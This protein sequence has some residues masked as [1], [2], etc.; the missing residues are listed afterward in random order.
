MQRLKF[1]N[2]ISAVV[3]GVFIGGS[4]FLNLSYDTNKA[5]VVAD[6][7]VGIPVAE[8]SWDSD[9]QNNA[10]VRFSLS[11]GQTINMNKKNNGDFLNSWSVVAND[12]EQHFQVTRLGGN[13]VVIKLAGTNKVISVKNGTANQSLLEVWDFVPGAWQQIWEMRPASNA[14]GGYNIVLASKPN[15]GINIPYSAHN[16]KITLANINQGDKDQVFYITNITGGGNTNPDPSPSTGRSSQVNSFISRY[17]GQAVPSG[18]D[19]VSYRGECVSLVTQ[20]QAFIGKKPGYWV[21]N[22]PKPAWDSLVGGNYGSI[23]K[24]DR[25]IQLIRKV[26]EVIPGDIL[27]MTGS[28]SHTAIATSGL[29]NGVVQIFESNANGR[30]PNTAATTGTMSAGRFIGAI[31]YP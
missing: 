20:W 9:V 24:G 7:K 15:M 27:I 26:S 28:P 4:S 14:P 17:R 11:N 13:R 21:G 16:K 30:A 1:S 6:I 22:Y 5:T 23:V 19:N 3:I 18:V 25:N 31:R 2:K 29:Q 8:A 12:S 10:V